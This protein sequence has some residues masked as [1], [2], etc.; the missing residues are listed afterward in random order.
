[1]ECRIEL[2]GLARRLLAMGMALKDEEAQAIADGIAAVRAAK[3]IEAQLPTE[4]TED[5]LETEAD[6]A[7][8]ETA[9]DGGEIL[10]G[11]GVRGDGERVYRGVN[12]TKG[13]KYQA[14]ITAYNQQLYLGRFDTPEEAARAYDAA[15]R[16]YHGSTAIVNFGP[17]AESKTDGPRSDAVNGSDAREDAGAAMEVEGGGG[18]AVKG[19]DG[20]MEKLA[21]LQKLHTATAAQEVLAMPF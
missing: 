9:T 6:G 3:T 8:G 7:K 4:P 2:D 12:M 15:A 20:T 16:K 13:N 17:D 19:E 14:R 11:G 5:E 21:A 1:M 18:V 10:F